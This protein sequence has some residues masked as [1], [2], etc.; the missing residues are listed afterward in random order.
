MK[1]IGKVFGL[2]IALGAVGVNM[3]KDLKR[4]DLVKDIRD[5]VY[6][7]AKENAR[8]NLRRIQIIQDNAK[9]EDIKDSVEYKSAIWDKLDELKR[10][11]D[12]EQEVADS[13]EFQHEVEKI[14]EKMINEKS[15]K[16][17]KLSDLE[18]SE[19]EEEQKED[20]D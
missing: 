2:G 18:T 7:H 16:T 3:I 1:N 20:E 15:V 8:R 12:L 13:W 19:Q 17:V 4:S 6:K 10:Q 11:S 14:M 5:V 9:E